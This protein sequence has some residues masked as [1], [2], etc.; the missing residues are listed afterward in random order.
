[1]ATLKLLPHFRLNGFDPF[2][3]PS[4][5]PIVTRIK[6]KG[7]SSGTCSV[8]EGRIGISEIDITPNSCSKIHP[9]LREDCRE[10]EREN[11]MNDMER[12]DIEI[13]G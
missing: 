11:E 6:S 1:M 7:M 9:K 2:M 8:V 13:H 10:R 4:P 5:L 12:P 3:S